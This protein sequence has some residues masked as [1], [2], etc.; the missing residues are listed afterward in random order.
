MNVN[1]TIE[2]HGPN[3]EAI[4]V[5]ASQIV[6]FGEIHHRFGDTPAD[7]ALGILLTGG[8]R[9]VSLYDT[10]KTFRDRLSGARG[11]NPI[12]CH[13]LDEKDRV[14]RPP[15]TPYPGPTPADASIDL[16]P[17]AK[18]LSIV[19]LEQRLDQGEQMQIDPSG[20]VK[21]AAGAERAADNESNAA[22][23]GSKKK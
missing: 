12:V 17:P 13:V 5:V 9:L 7:G 2:I 3:G 16:N 19:D 22:E 20:V 11:G 18:P 1:G 6:A 15:D 10:R 14:V 8:E 21:V 4:E 23:K